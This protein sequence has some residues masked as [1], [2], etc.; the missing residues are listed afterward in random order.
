MASRPRAAF[1]LLELL[2]VIAIMSIGVAMVIPVVSKARARSQEVFC[3]GNLRILS[4]AL[5]QYTMEYG[6]R[7]PFGLIWNRTNPTNGRPT[8][9]AASGLVSWFSSIDKYLTSGAGT[10]YLL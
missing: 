9:G 3:Q 10:L 2:I 6:D 8:D 4:T 5:M 1:T 7:Y